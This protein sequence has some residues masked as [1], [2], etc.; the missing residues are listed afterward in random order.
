MILPLFR[1]KKALAKVSELSEGLAA[2]YCTGIPVSPFH[3]YFL[4]LYFL[5][6]FAAFFE[7]EED[8]GKNGKES[9]GAVA[10][11]ALVDIRVLLPVFLYAWSC[12]EHTFETGGYVLGIAY[13]E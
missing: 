4:V 7:K 6:I 8:I 13:D 10:P 2:F 9:V 5:R 11:V 1:S 3:F 12:G